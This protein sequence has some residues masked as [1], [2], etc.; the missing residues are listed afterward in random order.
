M[1]L[2]TSW[3]LLVGSDEHVRLSTVGQCRLEVKK[4]GVSRIGHTPNVSL[5][6]YE[7]PYQMC[8]IMTPSKQPWS[9]L[10]YDHRGLPSSPCWALWG[11]FLFISPL[12]SWLQSH[13]W[14]GSWVEL[15]HKRKPMIFGVLRSFGVMFNNFCHTPLPLSCNAALLNIKSPLK[16]LKPFAPSLKPHPP[17][18]LS[19]IILLAGYGASC[20]LR[21]AE[22]YY[23]LWTK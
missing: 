20:T 3:S 13:S 10:T 18:I 8:I 17:H 4:R 9:L 21:K 15:V 2:C 11:L 14:K 7:V 23:R 1:W 16:I 5:D 6:R 19:F 22:I 12:L